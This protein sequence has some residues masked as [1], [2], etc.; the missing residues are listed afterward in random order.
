[1]TPVLA[2]QLIAGIR[3]K[4]QTIAEVHAQAQAGGSAWSLAQVHLLLA[5]DREVILSEANGM[6]LATSTTR[7]TE[8]E[9]AEAILAVVASF[10]GRPTSAVAIRQRLPAHFVTSD[11]QIKA[12]ARATPGLHIVGPGLIS[13]GSP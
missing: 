12:V 8:D 10:G 6:I 5:C 11:E 7:S 9:L 2:E 3:Q 13:V 1:M 4:P